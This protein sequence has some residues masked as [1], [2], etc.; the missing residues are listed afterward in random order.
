ML[1]KNQLM[2]PL[3]EPLTRAVFSIV[4]QYRGHKISQQGLGCVKTY[5]DSVVEIAKMVQQHDG[6]DNST[7]CRFFKGPLINSTATYYRKESESLLSSE[8]SIIEY[9]REVCVPSCAQFALTNTLTRL[10]GGTLVRP[11]RS[12]C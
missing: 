10:I 12:A 5:T 1:W 8:R 3:H 2:E 9:V 7:F 4:D 11:R 6:S